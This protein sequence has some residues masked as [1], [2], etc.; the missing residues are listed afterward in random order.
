[1]RIAPGKSAPRSLRIIVLLQAWDS[2][3]WVS[4]L[5]HKNKKQTNTHHRKRRKNEVGW[6]RHS[7]R[8]STSADENFHCTSSNRLGVARW[9]DV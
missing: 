8:Q 2:H 1:M 3:A 7:Q 9:A 6:G 5:F 4:Q